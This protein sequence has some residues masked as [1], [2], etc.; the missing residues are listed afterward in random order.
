MPLLGQR[1]LCFGVKA[2]VARIAQMA[3]LKYFD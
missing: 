3:V 2:M 1:M